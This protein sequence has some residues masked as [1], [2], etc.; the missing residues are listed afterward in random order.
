MIDK[1]TTPRKATTRK[2]PA[3]ATTAKAAPAEATVKPKAPSSTAPEG[4]PGHTWLAI[5]VKAGKSQTGIAPEMGVAPM[6]LNRIINGHGVPTASMTIKFAEATGADVD[7][8]WAEVG[9]YVLAQAKAAV[10]AAE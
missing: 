9:A 4:H 6:S 5:L 1:P 3:K 8:L 2:T 7:A 10:A